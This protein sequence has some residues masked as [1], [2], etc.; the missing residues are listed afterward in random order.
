PIAAGRQRAA[1]PDFGAVRHGRALELTELEKAVEED[2]QP[3]SDLR[4]R[5]R[6][7]QRRWQRIGPAAARGVA[8]GVVT[9]EGHFARPETETCD[10]VEV[11][12]LKLVGS[13]DLLRPLIRFVG[14]AVV[15]R[16]ELRRDLRLENRLQD[17]ERLLIE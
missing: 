10:V 13:D 14:R 2:L 1:R 16:D 4:K 7:A 12:V 8:P 9:Q 5:V 15:V 6:V 17:A 3:V 11:E